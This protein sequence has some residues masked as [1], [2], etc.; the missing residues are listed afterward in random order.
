MT[1][2]S[3]P[4]CYSVQVHVAAARGA[5]PICQAPT[6]LTSRICTDGTW[7][8]RSTMWSCCVEIF[9][10]NMLHYHH[11]HAIHRPR[12]WRGRLCF[13]QR[14][15]WLASMAVHA[16]W[17]CAMMVLQDEAHERICG[18]HR[19]LRRA[20]A[21]HAVRS[22]PWLSGGRMDTTCGP[23]LPPRISACRNYFCTASGRVSWQRVRRQLSRPL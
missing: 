3:P 20:R 9:T 16:V 15:I 5:Q 7:S 22:R 14:V 2:H 12:G 6:S 17:L 21:A 1:D 10:S 18:Q 11:W 13:S 19:Q 8:H 23:S 4:S